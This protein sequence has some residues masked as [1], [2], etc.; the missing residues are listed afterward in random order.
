METLYKVVAVD[1]LSGLEHCRSDLHP[2]IECETVYSAY[3]EDYPTAHVL[4]VP[5]E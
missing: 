3:V 1:P 2:W 5:V 4:I